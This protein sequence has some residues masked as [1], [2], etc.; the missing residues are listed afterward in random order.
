MCPAGPR[1]SELEDNFLRSNY[2][3]M[4]TRELAS[5]IGRGTGS[6]SD[7]LQALGVRRWKSRAFT[8]EEDEAIR[9]GFG[10][11]SVA[12]G[13]AL[14]RDAAVVRSRAVRLG[15]GKWKRPLKDFRGYKVARIERGDGSLSRRIGEHRDVMERT[16]RRSLADVEV[17]HHINLKKRDNRIENLYLCADGAAHLRTHHSINGLIASLLERGSIRFNRDRGVYELC[18]IS[19]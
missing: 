12:V 19:K 17:V 3:T 13:R 18:E 9:A 5:G 8:P 4:S 2:D 10:T 1:Y 14:G 11:S 6:V 16:L 7:R 15:R